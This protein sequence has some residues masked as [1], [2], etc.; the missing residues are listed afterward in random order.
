MESQLMLTK[1]QI[2][3]FFFAGMI[4]AFCAALFF[5]CLIIGG[6]WDAVG[7]AIGALLVYS[8]ANGVAW[9][10]VRPIC[11]QS[12][13]IIVWLIA[14]VLATALAPIVSFGLAL[15]IVLYA[16]FVYV[17]ANLLTAVVLWFL[18]YV[19]GDLHR[20]HGRDEVLL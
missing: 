12:S 19:E 8:V 13:S 7:P 4:A 18:A 17:P 10:L 6:G 2:P 3:R 5:E 20:G 15:G 14:S 11:R 1:K 9:V 16:W